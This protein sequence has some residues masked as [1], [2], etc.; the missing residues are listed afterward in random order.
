MNSYKTNIFPPLSIKVISMGMTGLTLTPATEGVPRPW[1]GGQAMQ[2]LHWHGILLLYYLLNLIIFS[3]YLFYHHLS[4]SAECFVSICHR[5]L[6]SAA[7]TFV[8]RRCPPSSTAIAQWLRSPW[9]ILDAGVSWLCPS[10]TSFALL[11]LPLHW[12]HWGNNRGL[13]DHSLPPPCCCPAPRPASSCP[14][15]LEWPLSLQLHPLKWL[16]V[17]FFYHL[18]TI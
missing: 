12:W 1:H 9:P 13:P 3:S 16:I 18:Y 4:L 15:L 5:S 8:D 10:S 17:V 7:D 2:R 14:L 11:P 6:V